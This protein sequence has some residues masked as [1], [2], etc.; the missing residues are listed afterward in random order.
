MNSRTPFWQFF[1]QLSVRNQHRAFT[2]NIRI[3][4]VCVER[5]KRERDVSE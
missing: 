1:D 2:E 4:C 5:E 3:M